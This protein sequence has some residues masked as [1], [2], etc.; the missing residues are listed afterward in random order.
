MVP[1]SSSSG[2]SLNAFVDL[3]FNTP[4]NAST[5]TATNIY[6]SAAETGCGG[7]ITPVTYVSGLPPNEVRMV[8]NSPLTAGDYYYVCVETGLQSATSVPA[9][10]YQPYFYTGTAAD[11]TLPT[12]VSAVPYNGATDVGVNVTPG[13]IFSKAIDPVS[14]NTNTFP[15]PMAARRWPEATGSTPPTPASSLCPTLRCRPTPT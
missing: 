8:P 1:S 10:Q 6:L 13:V 2:A 15:F 11:N 9:T 4:L 14:V 7:A 5:I 3:Q 12:I